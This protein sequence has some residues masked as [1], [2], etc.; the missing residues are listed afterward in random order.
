MLGQFCTFAMFIFDVYVYI[1][2]SF[3]LSQCDP[4][5][6]T[7]AHFFDETNYSPHFKTKNTCTSL[8]TASGAH[9]PFEGDTALWLIQSDS[10]SR[11]D[12]FTEPDIMP[13]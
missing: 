9:P 7:L 13:H 5:H 11:T 8:I 4:P 2:H 6:T 1:C 3:A 10:L 12:F